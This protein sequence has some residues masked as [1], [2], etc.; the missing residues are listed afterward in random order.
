MLKERPVVLEKD[1][2]DLLL[3]LLDLL[4]FQVEEK[5][6]EEKVDFGSGVAATL[7]CRRLVIKDKTNV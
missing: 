1:V 3:Q 2:K 6:V 5:F 7:P 4:G